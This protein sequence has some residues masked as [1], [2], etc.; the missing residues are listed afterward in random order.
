MA[1]ETLAATIDWLKSLLA[2]QP[3]SSLEIVF[4]GGEPLLAGENF[5]RQAI[6][7]LREAF[8]NHLRLGVQSN[9]WLLTDEFCDLFTE[10]GVSL[11]TSLDGPEAIN[12]AQ[13]GQGYFRRTMTGIQMAQRHGLKVGCICTFTSQSAPHYREIFDFFARQ[14]LD[15]SIHAAVPPLN[16]QNQIQPTW[17][18][19]PETYGELLVNLLDLYLTDLNRVRI[20]TLDSLC[21]SVSAGKG[22]ICSFGDCL[23]HY[24]AI[25]P[26]GSLY[27]CQRFVGQ[28][29]FCLGNVNHQPTWSSLQATPAW[30]VFHQ[31]QEQVRE[32]CRHCPHLAYCQGGCP[33]DTLAGIGG[34]CDSC[35]QAGYCSEPKLQSQRDPYCTAYQR[36]FSY[37]TERALA[38]V[39]SEE[40]LNE[41]VA[42]PGKSLLRRGSLL[43]LMRGSSHP[44]DLARRAQEIVAAVALAASPTP[45]EAVTRL[46]RAGLVSERERAIAS[47]RRLRQRLDTKPSGLLNLYLHLTYA[48]NLHCSHCYAN[49]GPERDLFA[50]IMP[51]ESVMQLIGEATEL[52]F[53]KV[54]I[55]GGEPLVHPE[56]DRLLDALAELRQSVKPLQLVL[57]TNLAV[58]LTPKVLKK[59]AHSTDQVAIS[60]DGDC[61]SHDARRG[62]GNYERTVANLQALV[63]EQPSAAIV[64]A[65]TLTSEQINGKAGEAV[66]ALAQELGG[67]AVRFKPLLPLGRAEQ[68]R[69]CSLQFDSKVTA[70]AREERID[71]FCPRTTCGVGYSLYVGPEGETYPCYAL[72]GKPYLLGNVCEA[73]GLRR[74][75]KSAGYQSLSEHTVDTNQKCQQCVLRYLCG[76]CCR[77]WTGV[78]V[79]D[80]PI[81]PN[82]D[83]PPPDC[84]ALLFSAR[85]LLDS[86]LEILKASPE[87]WLAAGLPLPE[88]KTISESIPCPS[89]L[90]SSSL[91]DPV[92]AKLP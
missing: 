28:S 14:G 62:L 53:R 48:C 65:A 34:G 46:E 35:P 90:S 75:V 91:A 11:G 44:A 80:R 47:L 3:D 54:V 13:R 39:F 86:A 27:P 69:H 7:R 83:D 82:L 85:A 79:G 41:V 37:I 24:L 63:A 55:T 36:I 70:T 17:S 20:H 92:G 88:P 68:D 72:V 77:A 58:P 26:D 52:D 50:K 73:G 21:R 10:Y 31:R 9:L 16:P 64:L 40:N 87:R 38:E 18:L 43:N 30:A 89:V 19:P 12:D 49:S 5:Y 57:R 2:D 67:L 61:V 51:V 1:Q 74:V 71:S 23:G 42:H 59:I 56:R 32:E 45:E 4:H 78:A 81:S 76:G 15:F 29:A 25:A 8:G 66:K 22:G 84:S 6:P 60:I 33:Y